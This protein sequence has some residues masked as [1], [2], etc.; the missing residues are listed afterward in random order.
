MG[1]KALEGESQY[2]VQERLGARPTL[3][4]HGITGGFTGEGS[5]TVIPARAKAKVSMRLVPEQ[6]PGEVFA[7]FNKHVESLATPGVEVRVTQ[8]NS[9][10]P[11]VVLGVDHPG[12]EAAKR[13][14][15]A[16]FGAEP[17][18]VREGGSIPVTTIFQ[19]ALDPAIVVT[20]FGLPDDGLHSPNEHF[21]LDHFHRG[22]EMVLHLM[23]ELAASSGR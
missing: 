21:S 13:A 8:V 17:V 1:V 2:S 3:D 6:D 9:G 15:R 20:G 11:P 14:Y 23:H 7:A 12:I 4:V 18:L 16:S 10:A 22:T 5:K 19:A